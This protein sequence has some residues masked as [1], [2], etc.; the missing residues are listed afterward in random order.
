MFRI[1]DQNIV[2]TNFIHPLQWT[3][4]H[5]KTTV[6]YWLNV[7]YS[8]WCINIVHRQNMQKNLRTALLKMYSKQY[9]S[10]IAIANMVI[11]VVMMVIV[12]MIVVIIIIVV[13][14]TVS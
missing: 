3:L 5:L 2:S 12:V 4:F 10:A 1:I 13:G 14:V 8:T 11:V 6:V 7:N 9:S